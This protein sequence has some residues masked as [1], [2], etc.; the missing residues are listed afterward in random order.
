MPP[1]R[2]DCSWFDQI[3]FQPQSERQGSRTC[4]API[5]PVFSKKQ[6]RRKINVI[7]QKNARS[8]NPEPRLSE[9]RAKKTKRERTH[10]ACFGFS[11]RNTR[12]ASARSERVRL[13]ARPAVRFYKAGKPETGR[14]GPP[15]SLFPRSE[16]IGFPTPA[17]EN[18]RRQSRK[19]EPS[20]KQRRYGNGSVPSSFIK[21]PSSGTG[22]L[23]SGR[24]SFRRSAG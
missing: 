4:P 6:L 1:F 12:H 14:Y 11:I 9:R 17:T 21:R 7:F 10:K 18:R 19:S 22:F 15:P 23:I 2:S 20:G 13:C 3:G 16:P 5:P 24:S 8:E